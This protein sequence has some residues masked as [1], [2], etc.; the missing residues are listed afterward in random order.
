M[1]CIIFS[2]FLYLYVSSFFIFILFLSIL[3][4]YLYKYKKQI[5]CKIEV[6]EIDNQFHEKMMSLKR[7]KYKHPSLKHCN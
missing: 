7:G 2:I 3:K 4:K 5:F 1:V 6:W